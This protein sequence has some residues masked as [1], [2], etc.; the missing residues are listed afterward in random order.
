MSHAM[1]QVFQFRRVTFAVRDD[2]A[3][4]ISRA[5]PKAMSILGTYLADVHGDWDVV[6][7][8]VGLSNRERIVWGYIRCC[9][10]WD[11]AIII[12]IGKVIIQ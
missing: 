2:V 10:G 9:C 6:W 5:A 7:R 8:D 11:T 4:L 1:Y 12:I 3:I